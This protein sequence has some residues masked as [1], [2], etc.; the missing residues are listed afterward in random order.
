[1]SLPHHEEAEQAIL[2]HITYAPHDIHRVAALVRPEHFHSR[3]NQLV[4]TAMQEVAAESGESNVNLLTIKHALGNR[5]I[6]V[7]DAHLAGLDLHMP[8]TGEVERLCD[9]IVE[10]FV[11]RQLVGRCGALSRDAASNGSSASALL[12]EVGRIKEE[13]EVQ[14]SGP[15]IWAEGSDFADSVDLDEPP[16]SMLG[17]GSGLVSWD[18]MTL[19]FQPGHLVVIAG[20]TSHGKS[21]LMLVAALHAAKKGAKVA[22]ESL[23]MTISELAERSISVLSQVPLKAIQRRSFSEVQKH[24]AD[25][26]QNLMAGLPLA[27]S[28]TPGRSVEQIA[29]AARLRKATSGLDLLC[30]DYLSHVRTS[31]SFDSESLRIGHIT[32]SLK[33]LAKDLGVPVILL[34]QISR[35]AEERSGSIP[36]LA[37]LKWSSSVEEDAD[38]V[39]FIHRPWVYTR[40]EDDKHKATIILAKNRGGA[41]GRVE[42][43]FNGPTVTF[44]DLER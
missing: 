40:A 1:M 25:E 13:L 24:Q 14:C 23:E 42:C 12:A 22:I 19:G 37:D 27:V 16:R 18:S 15:G 20:R 26:A 43:F 3:R 9:I 34:H 39:N 31:A 35:R 36:T 32:S 11:R 17:F 38:V 21:A 33:V 44:R 2:A 29:S 10:C 5:F 8:A 4:F 30:I 7:G 6:E 28:D 41:T